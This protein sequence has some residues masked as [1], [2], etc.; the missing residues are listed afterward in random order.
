VK[1]P[2]SLVAADGNRSNAGCHM[3]RHK[4]E[5]CGDQATGFHAEDRIT[6]W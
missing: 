1:R 4:P 5:G 2:H 6:A 3:L